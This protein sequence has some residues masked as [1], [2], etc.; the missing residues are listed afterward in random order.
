MAEVL[1]LLLSGRLLSL[2]RHVGL[3][4]LVITLVVG[5]ILQTMETVRLIR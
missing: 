3:K 1:L 4:N 5:W 2:V